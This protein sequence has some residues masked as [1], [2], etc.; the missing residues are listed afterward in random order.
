MNR[1]PIVLLALAVGCYPAIPGSWSDYAETV[2]SGDTEL[3]DEV[4]IL[5]MSMESSYTGN[6]WSDPDETDANIWW[7]WTSEA[8]SGWSPLD[9]IELESGGCVPE[10]E[11]WD[12]LLALFGDPGASSST[13]AGAEELELSWLPSLKLFLAESERL[14]TGTYDLEPVETEDQ[15]TLSVD[16]L[17]RHPGTPN[18]VGPRLD[19]E[20][21]ESVSLD[22]LGFSWSPGDEAA[23]YVLINLMPAR[24]EDESYV[25]FESLLCVAPYSAG[26]I[27][28]QRDELSDPSGTEALYVYQALLNA[29]TA[30]VGE[31]EVSAA[32]LSLTQELGFLVVE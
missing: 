8:L 20:S 16:S 2:D 12:E 30:P 6:Y 27:E 22:E 24:W 18:L 15:G 26:E 28:I 9:I 32:T 3:P 31:L 25:S 21:P 4:R 10:Q 11:S 7:G 23:D 19:G 13:L 5:G 29:S 1:A 17:F 14:S